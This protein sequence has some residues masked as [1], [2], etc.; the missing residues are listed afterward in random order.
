MYFNFQV[1]ITIFFLIVTPPQPEIQDAQP[2]QLTCN[3]D[4]TELAVSLSYNVFLIIL[5]SVLAFLTRKVPKNYKESRFIG[6]SVYTTLVIMVLF[7]PSYV[8]APVANWKVLIIS[9]ALIISAS[10]TLISL[11]LVKLYAIYLVPDANL[12]I[13]IGHAKAAEASW[14]SEGIRSGARSGRSRVRSVSQTL[15]RHLPGRTASYNIAIAAHQNGITPAA[16]HVRSHSSNSD[17]FPHPSL[18]SDGHVYP[19]IPEEGT[20]M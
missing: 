3:Q 5:C 16:S 8:N 4:N 14:P 12:N 17:L 10:V 20:W 7:V 9:F 6:F 18:V 11:F 19:V 2:R 15:V 1:G 13:A